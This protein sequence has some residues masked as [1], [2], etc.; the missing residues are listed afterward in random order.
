MAQAY[1]YDTVLAGDAAS[2]ESALATQDAAG[3]EVVGYSGTWNGTSGSQPIFY[4]AL[5]RRRI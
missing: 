3:W 5:L 4:T 2:F 1:E